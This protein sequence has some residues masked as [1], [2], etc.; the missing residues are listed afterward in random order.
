MTTVK[1]LSTSPIPISIPFNFD[2]D[3]F[4]LSNDS[5]NFLNRSNS[6]RLI[7]QNHNMV[8][9]VSLDGAI[10]NPEDAEL[11]L[12]MSQRK[13][14][15]K[16]SYEGVAVIVTGLWLLGKYLNESEDEDPPSPDFLT[17]TY[18]SPPQL[19]HAPP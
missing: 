12:K 10:P 19:H 4:L 15:M 3:I 18:P 17:N 11:D 16:V 9:V 13:L 2:L 14:C 1:T 7:D 5:L 8:G 6:I